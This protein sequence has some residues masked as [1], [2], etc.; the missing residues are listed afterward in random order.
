MRKKIY[1][2]HEIKRIKE[3]IRQIFPEAS[4]IDISI[5][6]DPK[7]N[8][9]ASIKVNGKR[10]QFFIASKHSRNIKKVLEKAQLAIIRQFHRMKTKTTKKIFRPRGL[11]AS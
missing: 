7:Q 11:L 8:Y 3:R 4:T 2:K 10:G 6:K 9:R 5:S 1:L